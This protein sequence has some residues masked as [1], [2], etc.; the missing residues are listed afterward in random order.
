MYCWARYLFLFVVAM[1]AFGHILAACGQKGP[2][3]LPE[4][5][6]ATVEPDESP[7]ALP[8]RPGSDEALLQAPDAVP[9]VPSASETD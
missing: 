1:L 2:L 9:G 8:A 7:S 4:P 3:S 6:T 5:P